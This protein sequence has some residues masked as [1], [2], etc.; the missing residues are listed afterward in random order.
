[1]AISQLIT[2]K[3]TLLIIKIEISQGLILIQEIY[4]NLSINQS[5]LLRLHKIGSLM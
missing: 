4:T 3:I 1:M 5:G 2:D